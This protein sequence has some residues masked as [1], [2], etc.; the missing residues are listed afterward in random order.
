MHT[1]AYFITMI[2][3]ALL[4]QGLHR[5]DLILDVALTSAAV[6]ATTAYE[7][8]FRGSNDDARNVVRYTREGPFLSIFKRAAF[9]LFEGIVN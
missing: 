2:V 6:A 1:H 9:T 3:P 7:L 5:T 4:S 8:F